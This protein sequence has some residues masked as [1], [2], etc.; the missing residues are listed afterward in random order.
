MTMAVLLG[1][2]LAALSASASTTETFTISGNTLQYTLCMPA[3]TKFNGSIAT[4]GLVRVWVNDANGA[5]VA[6]LGIIEENAALNFVADKEGN[7]TINLQNGIPTT[8]QV[9][10]SYDTDP[11]LQTDSASLLPFTYLPVFIAVTIAGAALI[12]AFNYKNKKQRR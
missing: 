10:L 5:T 7:Y 4:T 3:G 12:L 1:L 11:E 9:T 2:S 8:I 6:N